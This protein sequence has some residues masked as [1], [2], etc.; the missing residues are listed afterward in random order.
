MSQRQ[1]LLLCTDMDR[2][3]I[4][5]GAQPEHPLARPAFKAFCEAPDVTLTYVTGRHLALMEDAIHQY[6][7]PLP[8]YAITDVGTQIYHRT[9][10]GWQACENWHHEIN[11]A[12]GNCQP[13]DIIEILAPIQG[14]TLQEPEKQN[15][16]KVSFYGDLSFGTQNDY[17][18][19]AKTALAPLNID[20]SLIWSL[21]EAAHVGLLDVLPPN[22]TKRH[23]IEFLQQQLGLSL[24]NVIFAGDSGNDLPV[25]SSPI[26]AIL[27]ANASDD[28]K[29]QA[30]QEC[31]KQ[32][33]ESAFFQVPDTADHKGHYAAGVLQ[34]VRHFAPRFTERL[35][36]IELR[37]Q[38]EV[39]V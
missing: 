1:Q 37:L 10:S 29:R 20:T 39:S 9:Q 36:N 22:A 19:L 27:V 4:P 33:T 5:N 25:L 3:V 38:K 21:D 8:D 2:T 26:H 31:Q 16:H 23:A 14:L 30:W 32:H 7:L 18:A 6:N 15:T 35:D 17:L 34:G 13:H 12:W 11:Q 28:L 24:S